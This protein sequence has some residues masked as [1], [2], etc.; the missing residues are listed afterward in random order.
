M[1]SPEDYFGWRVIFCVRQLQRAIKLLLGGRAQKHRLLLLSR[2]VLMLSI[3]V[4][5]AAGGNLDSLKRYR[6]DIPK[7]SVDKA[8]GQLATQIDAL[9]LFPYDQVIS[10]DA[11]PVKGLYSIEKA[12]GILLQ[13]TGLSG[14]LTDGGVIAISRS[15]DKNSQEAQRM[16]TKKKF[17]ASVIAALFSSG[18]QL[19]LGQENNSNDSEESLVFEEIVVTGFRTSLASAIKAKREADNVIDGISAEDIGKLSDT[20]I[21]EALQRVTGVQIQRENGEGSFVSIRGMDPTFTKVTVNGQSITASRSRA[22]DTGFNLSILG[23]SVASRLEVIK[24]PTADMEEGGV[25]G[26]VNIKKLRPFD[27]GEFKFSASV[28]G[29]YEEQRDKTNPR[30]NVFYSD[31]FAGDTIGVSL[32]AYA[33]NRHFQRTRVRGGRP[34]NIDLPNGEA[35]GYRD[36]LNFRLNEDYDKNTNLS[37]TFEW[38]PSDDFR[39]YFDATYGKTEGIDRRYDSVLRI[40]DDDINFDDPAFST[41]DTNFIDALPYRSIDQYQVRG[42]SNTTEDNLYNYASG[43]D[44][45]FSERFNIK[46]EAAYSMTDLVNDDLPTLSSSLD[47]T[48]T[49]GTLGVIRY[50]QGSETN[51]KLD[52][53]ADVIDFSSVTPADFD[54]SFSSNGPVQLNEAEE[55]SIKADFTLT[56]DN[57][58]DELQF[59]FK[60][61]NRTEEQE[62]FRRIYTTEAREA[63]AV[64][65][66]AQGNSL[67][68]R[69]DDYKDL[70]PGIGTTTGIDVRSIGL[71]LANDPNVFFREVDGVGRTLFAERDV[72]A[73]YGLV[74]FYTEDFIAPIRANVGVRLVQTDTTARGFGEAIGENGKGDGKVPYDENGRPL[75]FIEIEKEN[76]NF[77]V[78]PSLNFTMEVSDEIQIRLALARVMRRPEVLQVTPSFEIDL[79]TFPTGEIDYTATTATGKSGNTDLD[80]FLAN[81]LDLTFEYY[82]GEEG[83]ISAGYFYKDVENFID[84]ASRETVRTIISPEGDERDVVVTLSEYV[85]GGSAEI[86]GVELSYQQAFTFLPSPFDGF[87]TAINYTYTKSEEGES[88]RALPGT[89]KHTFNATVYYEKGAG[90]S[91]LAYNYRDTFSTGGGGYREGLGQLDASLFYNVTDNLKVTLNAVN[92]TEEPFL[93]DFNGGRDFEDSGISVSAIEKNFS[94]Y[95]FS[96]RQLFMGLQYVY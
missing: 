96:G 8:L 20:N 94:D 83:L 42:F 70:L 60:Y 80:P 2:V 22:G 7:Q 37:A 93:R 81:Q 59:G 9:L 72:F 69:F 61:T 36:S 27:L 24:S 33:Y 1:N 10:V 4:S 17:L 25:G 26:S 54:T 53:I 88:G 50:G 57:V 49:G 12:L 77:E 82:M 46:M 28:E 67:L 86:Y 5:V 56:F 45:D 41:T 68:V 21:A 32:Q 91:R 78:L 18:T 95:E 85:N 71:G 90:G 79:E 62:V 40:R 31:L 35:G 3:S 73:L 64:A 75:G 47:V 14:D 16:K 74:K 30:I 89:S 51:I 38:K 55:K 76:S 19:G 87:G 39:T 34:R 92:L 84:R 23:S 29:V 48:P 66:A 6:F 63:A 65:A 58:I 43:F 52:D 44:W 13:G 11:N 15:T